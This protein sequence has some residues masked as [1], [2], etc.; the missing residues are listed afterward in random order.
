MQAT[1]PTSGLFGSADT[2]SE[3]VVEVICYQPNDASISCRAIDVH[4]TCGTLVKLLVD[5]DSLGGETAGVL[6]RLQVSAAIL[7]E[8]NISAE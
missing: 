8:H 1:N 3:S 6:R 5:F 7:Q 2:A 4:K